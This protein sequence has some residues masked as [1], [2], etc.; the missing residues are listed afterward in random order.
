MGKSS[1]LLYVRGK[2]QLRQLGLFG[3]LL[4]EPRVSGIAPLT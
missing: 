2:S 3:C 4:N 1:Q